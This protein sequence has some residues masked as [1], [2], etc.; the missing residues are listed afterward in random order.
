[1]GIAVGL[2]LDVIG[3]LHEF[4]GPRLIGEAIGI[5]DRADGHRLLGDQ[6]LGSDRHGGR[7]GGLL[8]SSPCE[9]V[10]GHDGGDHRDDQCSNE[11]SEL[12][13]IHGV[14]ASPLPGPLNSL[15]NQANWL[16]KRWVRIARPPIAIAT[17]YGIAGRPSRRRRPSSPRTRR[18]R[19]TGTLRPQRR[20]ELQLPA[21]GRSESTTNKAARAVR[22]RGSAGSKS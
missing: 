9:H 15:T 21:T 12:L 7:R 1:L 4:L 6:D 19:A 8:S 14:I 5:D 16:R 10:F 3:A 2:P 13:H 17:P 20:P 22:R 11:Q 18:W